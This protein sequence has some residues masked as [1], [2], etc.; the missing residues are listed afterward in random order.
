[1][2]FLYE[3]I[4]IPS[5]SHSSRLADLVDVFWTSTSSDP[6][7][8][9]YGWWV[10]RIDCPPRVLRLPSIID[11]VELLGL[12]HNLQ[13]LCITGITRPSRTTQVR[14]AKILQSRFSHSLRRLD[15]FIGIDWLRE[16]VPI[17]PNV[18]LRSLGVC[19]NRGITFHH[20]SFSPIT[21]L[22]LHLGTDDFYLPSTWNFPFLRNLT[23]FRLSETHHEGLIPF[24][25][26]HSLTLYCLCIH[27]T[28]YSG[29]QMATLISSAPSL[30][31]FTCDDLDVINLSIVVGT[32]LTGLTHLGIVHAR[33]STTIA[34]YRVRESI[35]RI[36]RQGILPDLTVIRLLSEVSPDRQA[37]AWVS[38][39]EDCSIYGVGLQDKTRE[40]LTSALFET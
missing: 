2:E 4:I 38:V 20:Q 13:I 22:S 28:R 24:I 29:E 6:D 33:G 21:T 3:A 19:I 11:F 1:M 15:M 18:E 35:L 9:G 37:T 23:L 27:T 36:F 8:R 40:P 26:Q 16:S 31:C 14:L 32:T 12:F 17:L 39:F 7:R 5:T 30:R 25:K 34:P 10:K